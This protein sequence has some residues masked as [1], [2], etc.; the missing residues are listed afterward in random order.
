MMNPVSVQAT[1]PAGPPSRGSVADAVVGGDAPGEMSRPRVVGQGGQD[2]LPTTPECCIRLAGGETPS[3][4]ELVLCHQRLGCSG[5]LDE[6]LARNT[7]LLHH[8]LKRFAHS[9]EPYEDL[10][11]VAYLGLVKAIQRFDPWR[12]IVFS[13][14]AVAVVDG[15][16]RHYLRD[17]VLMRQPRWARTA[18]RKIEEAQSAFYAEHKRFP[19]FTELAELVNITPEGV[20]EVI[21]GCSQPEL[22]SLDDPDGAAGEPKALTGR[23]IR[24][25]R[26]ESFTLPLEDR[27]ALYQAMATL[28]AAQKRLIYLLFFRELTQQE[29]ADELG[30][31]QR[32]VSRE[33]H[34]ALAKLKAVLTKK[35][36]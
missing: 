4:E 14:Y 22:Q 7:K 5:C 3:N 32:T 29:V 16:V 28:S 1:Y 13:T 26:H 27:I 25:L 36:F 11:Q 33:Q 10:L 9:R 6:L 31:T 34:R 19:S 30:M 20:L 12:G 23:V 15:E 21:R 2:V 17:S 18:Y 35:I 8:V 24:S